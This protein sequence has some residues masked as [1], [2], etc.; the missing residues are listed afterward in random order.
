MRLDVEKMRA[1]GLWKYFELAA[2]IFENLEAIERDK[3]LLA[4]FEN[5][6][7][8]GYFQGWNDMQ[9]ET[10]RDMDFPDFDTMTHG[11]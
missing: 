3:M 11:D 5:I 7:A 2:A 4:M 9:D 10:L 8:E 6:Y 1:A